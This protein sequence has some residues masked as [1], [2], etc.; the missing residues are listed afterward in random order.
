MNVKVKLVFPEQLVR[1]PVIARL[2][3]DHDV[4]PN[5]RKANVD[6]REGW[7]LCELNGDTDNIDSALEWLRT[8]GVRVELLG[9][10]VES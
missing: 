2:A 9:D 6:E 8:T 7:I 4:E 1:E 10:V 3:R 5:I